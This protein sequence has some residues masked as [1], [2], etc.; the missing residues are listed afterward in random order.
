MKY[1][2]LAMLAASVSACSVNVIVAPGATL[3]TD[4]FNVREDIHTAQQYNEQAD[5]IPILAELY[6]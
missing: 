6:E 5:I 1:L 2:L 3:A 4:S